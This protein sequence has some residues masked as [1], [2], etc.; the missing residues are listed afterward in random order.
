MTKPLYDTDFY[1]W[2]QTQAAALRAKEFAALDLDHLAEEIEDLGHSQ[3]DRL[4]SQLKRLLAHLLKWQY[5]PDK[6]TDSWQTTIEDARQEIDEVVE[7]YPSLQPQRERLLP[8]AYRRACRQAARET[9]LA[10]TTFPGAC[11]WSI[12]QVLDEDFWPET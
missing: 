8:I 4:S 9:R 12:A 7:D 6:R 2:T 3:R 5:Q 1:Q 11:P 10:L